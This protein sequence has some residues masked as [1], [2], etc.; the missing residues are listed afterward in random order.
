MADENPIEKMTPGQILADASV[1]EFIKAMG[2][3]IA[4]AQKALDLN[5]LAQVGEYVE[6]RPGLGGKS[7]LQLGLSPPFYHYQHADLTVSMQLTMK[8]GEASAFGIGGKLD[9]GFGQGGP[10]SPANAREAQITLKSLPASVTVDGAKTDAAGADLESAAEAVAQKL[11]TPAGKFERAYVEAQHT[12]VQFKLDPDTAKNPIKTDSGVA[13]YGAGESSV[14]VIR[15]VETPTAGASEDFVLASGKTANVKSQANELL[16]ARAVVSA[17]NALGGFK[18]KLQ[19]DPIGSTLP[20]GGGTL[21]IALFDSGSSVL[22]PAATEELGLLARTLRDSGSVVDVIGFTDRVA[23]QDYNIKL[24]EDRANAVANYLKSNGVPAAQI[25]KVET[26]GEDRWVGATDEVSNQQFRRAEVLLADSNDLLIIVD[27]AGTQLQATPTPDKTGGSA[28]GNGFIIVRHFTAQ[29]VDAT[30]VKVGASDTSVAISG[31]AVNSGGS[32]FAGDT[33]EAYAFN[34]TRDVNA[35]SATHGVRATRQGGVVTFADAKDV[36]LINLV[37]LSAN[38]IALSA[39]DGASITK[40]LAPIAAGPTASGDKP[41]I[42]VAVGLA[43]DYRTS[44]QFEQSVNG[45]SSISARIVA[46]PAPVEFLDE[47]K[48]YLTPAPTPTP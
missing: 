45:N 35:G 1:A 39:A 43:V 16:Y 17:I 42:S 6:P 23:S 27:S 30:A 22:K 5:S 24:G 20:V 4:D 34:L 19:R 13:F 21:G 29:A 46:V 12:K 26:K 47:I 41:K 11:R 3:S 14:G 18:A 28:S 44:R 37:T 25:R 15:I 38:D 31:A 7:L 40:A 33:P 2:L 8:V 36:V 10:Q 9:F 32:N 48:T